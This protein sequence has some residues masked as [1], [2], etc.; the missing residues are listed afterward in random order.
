MESFKINKFGIR[1]GTRDEGRIAQ[2]EIEAVISKLPYGE[3]L[4]L[5]FDGLDLLAYSFADQAIA[6]TLHRLVSGEYGD[7]YILIKCSK[8][9]IL[10]SLDVALKERE[11]T[12]LGID[13]TGRWFC[14]GVKRDNIIE[15]LKIIIDKKQIPTSEL[16]KMMNLSV[17][18]CNNRVS[19]LSRMKLIKRNKINN[20]EGGILYINKSVV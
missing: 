14:L 19:E 17:P 9:D 2:P 13:D 6:I 11:I 5:D 18:N 7:K 12:A 15:A 16:A 4:I 10:E 8:V 20:P 1:I 3:T